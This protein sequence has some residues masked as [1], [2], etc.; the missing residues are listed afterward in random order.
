MLL[1]CAARRAMAA[2]GKTYTMAEVASHKTKDSCW[3]VMEGKVFDV[4]KWLP[5]VRRSFTFTF[6]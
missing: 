6:T 5:D 3:M 1:L 2:A 4:T